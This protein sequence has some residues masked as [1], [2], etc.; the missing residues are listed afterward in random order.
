M[1]L[2]NNNFIVKKDNVVLIMRL[3]DAEF[4]DYQ[5]VIPGQTKRHIRMEEIK[6]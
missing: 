2:K 3:L 6:F 5:Q 4:P 1:K